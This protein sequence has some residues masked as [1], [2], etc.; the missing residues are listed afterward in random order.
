MLYRLWRERCGG[1]GRIIGVGDGVT[2]ASDDIDVVERGDER[3]DG[4]GECSGNGDDF[5]EC[6]GEVVSC[7]R[8]DFTGNGYM[9]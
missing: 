5:G 9:D 2:V 3:G 1:D 8:K 7:D 4:R 6:S